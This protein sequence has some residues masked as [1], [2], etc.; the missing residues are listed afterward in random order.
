MGENW[1][2]IGDTISGRTGKVGEDLTQITDS[3]R[4]VARDSSVDIEKI[5]EVGGELAKT[6]KLIGQPLDDMTR[7]VSDLDA[8]TGENLNIDN[9][10]K[11][12]H[13][14]NI[15]AGDQAKVL[16]SL[17][18]T[19]TNTEFTI[20]ELVSTLAVAG[21]K[22]RGFHLDLGESA[23][24]LNSLAEAGVN[25]DTALK[26]L[27][28]ALGNLSKPAQGKSALADF[29]KDEQGRTIEQRFADV[30]RRIHDLAAA[31]DELGANDLGK[32]VFGRSWTDIGEPI[33]GDKLDVDHLNE[34]VEHTGHTIAATK[35]ATDDAA[36]GFQNLKNTIQVDLAPAANVV[37][38]DI[39]N[40]IQQYVVRPIKEA[41]DLINGLKNAWNDK[42]PIVPTLPPVTDHPLT[43]PPIGFTAGHWSGGEISGAGPKG[44]DSVPI[45]AAP[46]EHM[47][48]ADDVD[49]MGGQ[50]NVY[51]FRAALHRAT[52]GA[53]DP[54]GMGDPCWRA[55]QF[56]QSISGSPYGPAAGPTVWDCSGFMSDLYAILTGKPYQGSERYFTTEADFEAL[57][58]VKGYDPNSPFKSAC[59]RPSMAASVTWPVRCWATTSN[60]AAGTGG[61][62]SA[63]G[64][65]ARWIRSSSSTTIC[66]ETSTTWPP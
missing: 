58:F 2:R 14:F 4:R 6:L 62:W 23:V 51:A 33:K 10:T 41:T 38:Q 28:I 35:A 31:G 43:P 45:W 50:A 56:A 12:F 64:Q 46:G 15:E 59:P 65:L 60:P 5:A 8:L 66:P 44:Q 11:L 18:D 32:S 57:G 30:V 29:L 25:S 17:Y 3:I 16:D 55:L 1:D 26:S 48:T 19:Y 20:N 39:N 22:L 52:G 42:N 24:L 9:L 53:V 36:Q 27:G 49:A 54:V 34:S 61:R 40:L 13:G 47:F 37:F 21:P 7:R 63:R